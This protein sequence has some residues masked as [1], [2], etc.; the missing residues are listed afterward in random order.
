[1]HRADL[2]EPPHRLDE[3]AGLEA[4]ALSGDEL[5]EHLAGVPPLAVDEVAEVALVRLLVVRLQPLL[6]RPRANGVADVVA[7]VGGEPA[8]LD[9]EHLVPA[10]GPV[11]PERRAFL[12]L[13]ERV[14]HLVPVV[15]DRRGGNDRLE[16]RVGDPAE[17]AQRVGDLVGLRCELRLVREVL[18]PATAAGRVVLA[19]GLDADGARREDLGRERLGVVP[20]HLRHARA[21][22]VARKPAA[23]EHD[24]AVQPRDAV[25]AVGE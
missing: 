8:L 15:E 13:R 2:R 18:E 20:L 3:V 25:P 5:H 17:P 10:A 21:H 11:Q 22:R 4:L 7:E 6:A 9:L 23:D 19:R 16:R 12:V 1:M 14:L 24:E